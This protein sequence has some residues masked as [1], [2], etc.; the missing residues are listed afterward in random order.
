M[1]TIK[2]I[3]DEELEITTTF[4]R[5]RKVKKSNILKQKEDIDNLLKKFD[6]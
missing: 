6:K 5:V 1:E 4:T 3:S 2:K